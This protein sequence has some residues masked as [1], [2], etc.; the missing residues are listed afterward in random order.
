MLADHALSAASRAAR[1]R[2]TFA[3]ALCIHPLR[4]PAAISI[5]SPYIHRRICLS[6]RC[7]R[8]MLSQFGSGGAAIGAA[9]GCRRFA[10]TDERAC[11]GSVDFGGQPIDVEPRFRQEDA[12]IVKLIGSPRFDL[13]VLESGRAKL[14]GIFSF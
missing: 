9:A 8:D 12:S 7:E 10:H 2:S 14:R 11:H 5:T 4:I 13:D 1:S 3:F 6:F